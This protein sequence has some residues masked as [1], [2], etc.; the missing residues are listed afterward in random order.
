M[1]SVRALLAER[2]IF[3]FRM[4]VFALRALLPVDWLEPERIAGQAVAPFCVLDLRNITVAPLPTVAGISSI[5]CAARYAVRDRRTDPAAHGVFVSE[6]QTS[7]AFGAWFT[8]LGYSAPHPLVEATIAGEGVVTRV[9]VASPD[10]TLLFA[11]TVRLTDRVRSEV[12]P[13]EREFAEFIARGVRSFGASRYK[14]RLT[15]VDLHKEDA[16]YTSLEITGLSGTIVKEWQDGGGT[17]DGGFRTTGGRYE[18][19]YHGLTS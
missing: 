17:S 11:A 7:S 6:R 10:G 4:P 9:R 19:T 8:S 13:S 5:S 2:F 14:D 15:L 16:T 12:F 18:W 3:N 1:P